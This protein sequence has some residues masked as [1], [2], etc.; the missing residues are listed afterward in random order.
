MTPETNEASSPSL[1][2]GFKT[3]NIPPPNP[4]TDLGIRRLAVTKARALTDAVERGEQ[5]GVEISNGQL[6]FFACDREAWDKVLGL[7]ALREKL[8]ADP[9][10]LW[11]ACAS[12]PTPETPETAIHRRIEEMLR[13]LPPGIKVTGITVSGD[14]GCPDINIQTK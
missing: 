9:A 14:R 10:T 2:A 11:E 13:E 7:D 3:E 6:R 5:I 8:L 4:V 12:P 1:A